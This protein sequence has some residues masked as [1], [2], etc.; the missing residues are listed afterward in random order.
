MAKCDFT[1]STGEH[2]AVLGYC[3][4]SLTLSDAFL[5]KATKAEQDTS[6]SMHSSLLDSVRA[7]GSSFFSSSSLS[8]SL[9]HFLSLSFSRSLTFIPTDSFAFSRF[10]IHSTATRTVCVC[11][12]AR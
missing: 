10:F 4:L 12:F 11:V 9:S 6:G 3:S 8:L 7:Y 1:H 5:H 2:L